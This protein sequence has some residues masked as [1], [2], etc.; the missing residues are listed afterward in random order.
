MNPTAVKSV[1]F[2]SKVSSPNMEIRDLWARYIDDIFVICHG[3]KA[4]FI[5][6]YGP[7]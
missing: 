2:C 6:M 7:P 3:K 5:K 1:M 4:E